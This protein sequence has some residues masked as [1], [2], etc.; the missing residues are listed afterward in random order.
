MVL[1]KFT[2]AKTSIACIAWYKSNMKKTGF[3]SAPPPRTLEVIEEEIIGV[4]LK[5]ASLEEE[6]EYMKIEQAEEI[7]KNYEYYKSLLE[8]VEK[9]EEEE[10]KQEEQQQDE[11]QEEES[12]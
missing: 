2:E 5:L 6:Y 4:K 1:Q 9:P 8:K 10:E 7:R 3:K 12:K 11:Q